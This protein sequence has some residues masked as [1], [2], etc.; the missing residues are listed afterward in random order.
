MSISESEDTDPVWDLLDALAQLNDSGDDAYNEDE[1]TS[2]RQALSHHPGTPSS[3]SAH[4]EDQSRLE[5]LDIPHFPSMSEKETGRNDVAVNARTS[6]PISE[7][8]HQNQEHDLLELASVNR[9]R[10]LIGT[11]MG[12]VRFEQWVDKEGLPGSKQL[13]RYYRDVRAT[14]AVLDE[15]KAVGTG[16]HEIYFGSQGLLTEQATSLSLK[17]V[18]C[19]P[20]ISAAS[21]GMHTAQNEVTERLYA[22]EFKRFIAGKLTEQAKTR[23]QYIPEHDKRGDLGEVFCIADPRLP[24][25]PLVL[26]SDAFCK[27]SEYPRDLLIGRNCRFLQGPQTDREAVKALRASIEAD[28]SGIIPLKSANGTVEYLL[29]A[30]IDVT[31]VMSK[32]KSYDPLQD[33]AKNKMADA[34]RALEEF[35]FSPELIKSTDEKLKKPSVMRQISQLASPPLDHD[36]TSLAYPGP[37]TKAP[38]RPQPSAASLKT[39][40]WLAKLGKSSSQSSLPI[41]SPS[42]SSIDAVATE[43]PEHIR[44]RVAVFTAAH[45]KLILFDAKC[46]RIQ[47]VTPA[48]LAYLRHPIRTPKDRFSSSLLHTDIDDL[49]IGSNAIETDTIKSAVRTVVSNQSTHSVYAG[50]LVS[51]SRHIPD[52]IADAYTES[53]QRYARSLL[54]LTPVKDR[55]NASQMYVVVIG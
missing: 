51:R 55:R 25:Q 44:D 42:Q 34:D 21:L 19:I 22:A 16:L 35:E 52:N 11:H 30:Q 32:T 38:R 41:K 13:L 33:L 45:S 1:L 12:F 46:R 36:I 48:L 2:L 50:L 14:A 10:E 15:A 8:I 9:F 17:P 28:R 53:G 7:G 29:G 31:R 43:V 54:H 3:S 4:S 27:L 18:D 26:I 20:A 40:K 49:L 39:S 47:Y 23:L 24:D 37:E 6:E 5:E